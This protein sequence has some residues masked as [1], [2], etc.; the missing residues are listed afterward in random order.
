MSSTALGPGRRAHASDRSAGFANAAQHLLLGVVPVVVVAV[1][2]IVLTVNRTV[3]YDFHWAYYPAASRLLHGG[4]P[5]GMP[6]ADIAGGTAFVYP[7]FSA[8]VLVPFALLGHSQS[9]EVYR[10]LCLLLIP[11]TLW[12]AG[13]RDWRV[14]GVTLIWLPVTVGWQ[15]GNV[16]VPLTFLVALVWRYR[17]RPYVAGLVTAAAVSLK[18]FVWPLGLWLLATRRIRATIWTV[19]WA[20]ALNLLAWWIVGFNEVHTYLRLSGEVTDALWR[21]GYSMLAVAHYLG[22]GRGVGEALLILV[23]AA[24]GLALVYAGYVKRRERDAMVLAVALMLVAS[25]LVWSHYFVLLLV[26]LALTRPRFRAIWAAPIAMWVCPPSAT[27]VSWQAAVA[28]IVTGT[29]FAVA[30][31]PSR[32]RGGQ[33]TAAIAPAIS[34]KLSATS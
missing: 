7:A 15:I 2:F 3:A 1:M 21:G 4:N 14:Y 19:V 33:R 22:F 31:R 16:S 27:V 20:I 5:Y 17:D 24:V 30:L 28:W 29:C 11:G 34:P 10:A 9:D 32:V 6:A 26:P 25:P 12:T 8:V 18:P 13:V 23:S